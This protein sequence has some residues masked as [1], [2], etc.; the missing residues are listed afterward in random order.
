MTCFRNQENWHSYVKKSLTKEK[1]DELTAH[2]THCPDCQITVAHI[3]ETAQIL[4]ESRTTLTPPLDVKV[5]VML[6]I[7]KNRYKERSDTFRPL[8]KKNANSVH[9]FELKNWGLSMVAAGIL[10]FVLNLTFLT[11]ND[12]TNRVAQLNNELEKQTTLCLE[13]MTQ[14]TQAVLQKIDTLIPYQSKIK[15]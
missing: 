13:K 2:L 4:S 7:D 1:L 5:N 6:A 3:R 8:T 12:E 15:N 9:L 11:P 10:L 14:A